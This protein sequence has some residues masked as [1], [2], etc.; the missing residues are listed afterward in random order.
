MI[1]KEKHF[2]QISA[3]KKIG[4]DANYI[5]KKYNVTSGE[6]KRF[7]KKYIKEINKKRIAEWKIKEALNRNKD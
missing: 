2:R 5:A 1:L 6:L 7:Y 4:Y 3:L